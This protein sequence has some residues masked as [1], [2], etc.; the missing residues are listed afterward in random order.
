MALTFDGYIPVHII[1][2]AAKK[3]DGEYLEWT[4]T[5]KK[6]KGDEYIYIS[7]NL[8]DSHEA[9]ID[10]RISINKI[11]KSDIDIAEHSHLYRIMHLSII[12]T[13]ETY[14]CDTFIGEVCNN[15]SKTIKFVERTSSFNERNL[16][17]SDL[18][19]VHGGIDNIV[20]KHLINMH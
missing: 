6:I 10:T 4:P 20:K 17:L 5:E 11:I 14:L 18:F 16:K 9:F 13:L 8:S 12:T 2:G 7:E 19:K 1:A 15:E 3:L